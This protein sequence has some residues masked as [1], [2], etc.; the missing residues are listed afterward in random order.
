MKRNVQKLAPRLNMAIAAIALTTLAGAC[1][2]SSNNNNTTTTTTNA[3]A[4]Y[5]GTFI[6][7]HTDGTGTYAD[8]MVITAG[9]SSSAIVMSSRTSTGS[10]YVINGAVSGNAMTIA[11]QQVYI[12]VYSTTYTVTGTGAL[13]GSTLTTSTTYV[14]PANVTTHWAF[15]GT[16]Q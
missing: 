6:G 14:S 4:A 8:T 12:S 16:K 10:D 1:S 11:S 7:T 15:T 9:S 5:L 13:S 2:K 3:N